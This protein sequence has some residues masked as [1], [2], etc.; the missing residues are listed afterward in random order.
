M[1]TQKTLRAFITVILKIGSC[2]AADVS[3]M[4]MM[5][6]PEAPSSWNPHKATHICNQIL[7]RQDIEMHKTLVEHS[8]GTMRARSTNILRF[9]AVLRLISAHATIF[10]V[11]AYRLKRSAGFEMVRMN[12]SSMCLP[13]PTL[14][15]GRMKHDEETISIL[16]P[17]KTR[18]G[19]NLRHRTNL[20]GETAMWR[21][22]ALINRASQRGQW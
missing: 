21:V 22:S 15:P 5:V 18:A 7:A 4:C 9:A 1:G 20:A 8:L 6:E 13:T 10:Q 12:L 11:F 2:F 14:E 16:A 19:Q 17:L 3:A